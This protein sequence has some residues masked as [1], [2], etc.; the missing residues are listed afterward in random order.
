MA[1]R[2]GKMFSEFNTVANMT[3]LTKVIALLLLAGFTVTSVAADG[4]QMQTIASTVRAPPS[5]FSDGKQAIGLDAYKGRFVLVNFWATWCSPCVKEM[6]AL[7]R[8][9][10]RLEKKGVV[11]VAISQ[12]EGGAAQVRPFA[13][14]LKLTKIRILYD[15]EKRGFRD[16]ALRGLPTTILI[17]PQGNIV[18]RLE[19]SAT[20]DEGAL[21]AQVERLTT[22]AK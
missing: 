14:K 10:A 20:W 18:A 4:K 5:R 19:G 6:P 3:K 1:C 22:A 7:D 15:P 9:A 11:V 21:A 8:L 16:Y 2:S 13:E 17:S 12:D